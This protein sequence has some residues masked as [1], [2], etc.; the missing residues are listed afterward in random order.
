MILGTGIDLAEVGRIR[1][2]AERFGD[3]FLNRVYTPRERARAERNANKYE[4]YAARFAAKE[5][6][7]KAIGTGMRGGVRW[8]DFEVVNLP[9][10]RT[11]EA[12]FSS[13]NWPADCSFRVYNEPYHT[14]PSL[15]RPPQNK[16]STAVSMR[17][18][19]TTRRA[20]SWW[21]QWLGRDE[22]FFGSYPKPLPYFFPLIDVLELA[23]KAN[24]S[25]P[26]TARVFVDGI[27]R[28]KAADLP[29]ALRLRGVSLD[30]VRSGGTRANPS[31]GWW[32]CGRCIRTATLGGRE[33][34]ELFR[35]ASLCHT[36]GLRQDYK[37]IVRD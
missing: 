8:R 23:I 32:I 35:R 19:R 28:K 21:W 11:A 17:P 18:A 33:E 15:C 13:H 22:I 24:A 9:S 5:A 30:M 7:M 16:R 27:D 3:R 37:L 26:Y 25:P 14:L 20:C 4:R 36:A 12:T 2:A 6:A 34:K 1:H 29:N 10:G 31:S